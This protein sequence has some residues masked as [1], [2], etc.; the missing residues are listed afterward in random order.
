MLL[1]PFLAWVKPNAS[2]GD[3]ILAECAVW[4]HKGF[5]RKAHPGS[6]QMLHVSLA[7]SGKALCTLD[8]QQVRGKSVK[9]LKGR[10]AKEIA[11]SRFRQ[12]WFGEDGSE[13]KDE[14]KLVTSEV[15]IVILNVGPPEEDDEV[16]QRLIW[17]IAGNDSA[18][19]EALLH[20]PVNPDPRVITGRSALCCA[21]QYGS[22]KCV[23]LL[24]EGFAD[25]NQCMC[26]VFGWTPV[27]HMAA[28]G[29]SFDIVQLLLEA[30]A[31]IDT[32]TEHSGES[33]LHVAAQGGNAAMVQLLLEAGAGVNVARK[34]G[35]T[36]LHVAA[37][38]GHSEIV[39]LLHRA[40][41]NMDAVGKEDGATALQIAAQGGNA[42]M[43]QL[44]LEAGAD[45]N[46]AGKDG[47]TALRIAAVRGH[48]EIV[49]LLHEANADM[50]V[51]RKENGATLLRKAAQHGFTQ[52]VQL[53]RHA[54]AH[55]CNVQ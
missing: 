3:K 4:A 17:A 39:K 36:A 1:N 14:E 21:V 26:C 6:W 28:Q 52:I 13:L 45:M 24:L 29:G 49:R 20:Q 41:A 50:G 37:L 34:D 54:G 46:V 27:L 51:A 35:V 22:W 11:V 9:L 42:A 44:L 38:R 12:R 18:K 10:V 25:P 43:V 19:V 15:K 7:V 31:D 55:R 30:A 48:S 32:V 33:A 53:F 47:A 16:Y 8:A 5:S 40:G 23:S 2:T